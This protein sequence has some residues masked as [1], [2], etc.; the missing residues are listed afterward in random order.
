MFADKQSQ[1]VLGIKKPKLQK[2][3][4]KDVFDFKGYSIYKGSENDF[5]FRRGW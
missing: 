1:K 3:V 4:I 2:C 5:S